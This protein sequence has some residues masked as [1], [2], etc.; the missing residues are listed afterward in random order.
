MSPAGIPSGP[1]TTS[2][3]NHQGDYLGQVPRRVICLFYISWNIQQ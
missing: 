2:T 1:A 3:G